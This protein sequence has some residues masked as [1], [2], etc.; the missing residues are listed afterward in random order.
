[1]S[2][3]NPTT[4]Q[5]SD[6]GKKN[7]SIIYWVIIL[8][9]IAACIFI[10]VNKN[11]Q[12]ADKDDLL[13]Q[14][15]QTSDSMKTDRATLQSDFDAASM[16]IDQLTTQNSKM[17]SA[18]QADKT[19]MAAMQ[20][21]IKTILSNKNATQAEL[22][23]AREM[24]TSLTNKTKELEIRIAELEKKNTELTGQNQQLSQKVDSTTAQNTQLKT[25]GS[26]LHASN[27]RMET[28]HDKRNGKEK[29]T[30][31][32]RKVDDLRIKFDIDENRIAESGPKQIYLRIMGPDNNVFSSTDNA[33]GMMTTSTGNQIPF[34]VMKSVNL[35]QNQP[36][37]DITVDW[38]PNPKF[39]RGTYTIEIYNGGYKVGEGK[40]TLK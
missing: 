13:K 32:H 19:Q 17:D 38:H 6:P 37:N 36:V 4:P 27:I 40:V 22:K 33:S 34:S 7:N 25:L 3:F 23:E 18:L 39:E 16:K 12:I 14:Q 26:V 24:I 5:S 1:M 29:E 31:R 28:L 20:G 8:V 2:Q 15:Q 21:K 35:T 11:K 10:F 9:L 30:K